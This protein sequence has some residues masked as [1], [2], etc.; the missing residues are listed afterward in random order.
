MINPQVCRILIFFSKFSKIA[1]LVKLPARQLELSE[2]VAI[3]YYLCRIT[4]H[5]PRLTMLK[6]EMLEISNITMVTYLGNQQRP[7]FLN[8]ALLQLYY[9]TIYFFR[10]NN[11]LN[12]QLLNKI[13]SRYISLLWT[14]SIRLI[15]FSTG[16]V[17][18]SVWQREINWFCTI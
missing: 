17:F 11:W 16:Y 15:S 10:K 4:F 14:F 3:H 18:C 12:I 6:C 2:K 7:L 13:K 5:L 8:P 9:N 1:K